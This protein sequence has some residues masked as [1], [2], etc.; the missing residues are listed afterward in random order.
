MLDLTGKV[1]IVTG[2]SRGIGR[3]VSIML[4]RQGANVAF[5]DRAACLVD[6]H[7]K[8]DVEA[9]GRRSICVGGD[10]TDPASCAATVEETIREFGRVDILVNNAGITRDDLAMRM[11]DNAWAE[12]INTNLTGSFY[13]ARAVLR[14]MIRQRSGRIINMSSVSGQMGNAGQA[15]YS[16]SKAGLIGLTKA[17]A[18]EVASRGITVNAVAPGF[19]VTELTESLPDNVKDGIKAATPLGRFATPDEIASAVCFLASDEAAYITGQVLG[20]DGGLAMM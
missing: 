1:A 13:M 8:G 6:D 10:V 19:V 2:G 9:L 11:T 12:V 16:A 14:P 20:V 5:L 17:L 4:A 18:R 3:A 7:T 15:N